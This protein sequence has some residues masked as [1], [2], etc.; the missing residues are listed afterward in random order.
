M[1]RLTIL[2]AAIQHE[3]PAELDPEDSG[4]VGLHAVSE[5]GLGPNF[6]VGGFS[7]S[8]FLR[9]AM[10]GSTEVRGRL[11]LIRH[12]AEIG[13]QEGMHLHLHRRCFSCQSTGQNE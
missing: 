13:I 11:A 1:W 5:V 3:Q 9:G 10:S 12:E 8:A 2:L 6:N 4:D 7:G